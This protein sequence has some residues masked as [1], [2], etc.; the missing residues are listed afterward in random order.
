MNLLAGYTNK[1]NI[2]AALI[3]VVMFFLMLGSTW[4]DSAI[5]DELAHI[6]AGFGYVVEQ[7]Y[8][9]NP[10]HPPLLKTLAAFS[11]Q[12]F[13]HPYFPTNTP[14]WQDDINGQ[15]AQGAKFLYESGN[16]ADRIIFWSRIPLI[17]LTILFGSLFYLWIK[18]RF[19]SATA[20]LALTFFAFSP[21]F[22]AHGRYV[23]TDVGAAFGFFIAITALVNFLE[24]PSRRN[25]LI[26]GLALGTAL[27]TK[28]SLLLLLPIYAIIFLF[29]LY[30]LPY[31]HF[32]ERVR[33]G[34]R[35][36]GKLFVIGL[37]ALLLIWIVYALHVWN[38][39]QDRELS[40]AEFI[41]TSF[42][43]RPAVEFD[44]V[45]I[46]N[47]FTRPLGQY[48]LGALM[49]IQRAA[50]GNDTFFL[51]KV[52]AAGSPF[53]FP[54][55]YAVKEALPFH[56]FTLI[57]LSFAFKKLSRIKYG[58]GW[59]K[60]I[61]AA[62]AW[63]KDHFAEFTALFFIVI[64]WWISVRSPLN[65]GIRHVLPTFPFIYVLVSRQ[66]VEWIH[67]REISNPDTWFSWF[68]QVYEVYI[69]S[70]PKI[71]V[72]VALILWLVMDAI[73][74]YPYFLSFY[75]ELA[76]GTSQGWKI[77]VDSNYDWGQDL[78]RLKI[79]MEKLKIEKIYLDYFG[80]G[81]PRYYLKDKFEP[82]QSARGAPPSGSYFAISATFRQGA[83]GEPVKGFVRR[84][85]DSYEWL[86][87]LKP[88]GRAGYSI[89]I[90]KIP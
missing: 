55:L 78:K 48:L 14:Y 41:L 34:L 31:L 50:G 74:A 27:L 67:S 33:V 61:N 73:L 39:P 44:L 38:Y 21:T 7:D 53:Y 69:K 87:P 47:K 57:A 29:W 11:A 84:I 82:W 66:I 13:V 80:G 36:L 2:L 40:D 19:G 89:F 45:L 32:H 17:L 42:G 83:F 6:P 70:L 72:V 16:D 23:T 15:W 30:V 3:L 79:E 88:I 20:I 52:S 77:A 59:K 24:V 1:I 65:I 8:R 5:M 56:I 46:Q 63:I 62:R 54:L 26:A 18:Q 49:V 85:E 51:G 28:F 68:K 75:N 37:I 25:T 10:E 71:L 60:K 76:G 12:I 64:Y 4:N 81:S 22:L 58:P 43:F 35:L 86:K 9:L 90:Y